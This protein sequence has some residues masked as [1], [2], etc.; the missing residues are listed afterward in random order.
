[1]HRICRLPDVCVDV[2]SSGNTY[3]PDIVTSNVFKI[4]PSGIV[5]ATFNTN[6]P[7]FNFPH[8]VAVDSSDNIFVVDRF[9]NRVV[10]LSPAGKLR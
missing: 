1:M 2:D 10:K 4:S 8:G 3:K 6:S 7:P 5:L 9:N